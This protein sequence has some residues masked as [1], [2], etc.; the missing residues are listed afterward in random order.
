MG[1]HFSDINQQCSVWVVPAF[2]ASRR[3]S[4]MRLISNFNQSGVTGIGRKRI[5]F[6]KNKKQSYG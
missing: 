5:L 4:C 1:C 2:I 6:Y 3:N